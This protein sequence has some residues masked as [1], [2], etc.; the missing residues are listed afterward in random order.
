MLRNFW[1]R[2]MGRSQSEAAERELERERGDKFAGESY[3][4]YQADEHSE[5]L[6]GGFNPGTLVAR[7]G[8][9]EVR[10][11]LPGEV[12]EL[13]IHDGSQ[14]KAGDALADISADKEHVWEALRA[15]YTIGGDEDLEDI[16]RY[17]RGVPGMPEKVQQQARL[18]LQAI[19]GRRKPSAA[20]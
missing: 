10:S 17:V 9:T 6:L 4:D 20:L 11:Q 8:D 15:L 12:Q 7:V 1:N 2:L 16:Q 14:V 18:T 5:E 13:R 19:Q 3:E